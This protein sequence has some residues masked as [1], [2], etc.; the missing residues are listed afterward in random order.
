MTPKAVPRWRLRMAEVKE[1]AER[2]FRLEAQDLQAKLQRQEWVP[3]QV[4]V[5]L[6]GE[7]PLKPLAGLQVLLGP[8][9]TLMPPG[10]SSIAQTSQ[11]FPSS[12][13]LTATDCPPSSRLFV[14]GTP[15]PWPQRPS[16]P[17]EP[18]AVPGESASFDTQLTAL[19][20]RL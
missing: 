10:S 17:F 2:Q 15:F 5:L 4:P 1:A 16:D 8:S 6:A 9:S 13:Q 14:G 19:L 18:M 12:L 3:P 11:H 20:L 7:L